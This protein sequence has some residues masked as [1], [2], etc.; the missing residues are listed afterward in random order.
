VQRDRCCDGMDCK[1]STSGC[2]HLSHEKA[3]R[4]DEPRQAFLMLVNG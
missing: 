2:Q 4:T 3:K 1:C